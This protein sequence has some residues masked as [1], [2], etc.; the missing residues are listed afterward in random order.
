MEASKK[1]K[2]KLV[3]KLL[4]KYRLLIVNEDTYEERFSIG[5]TRL[6]VY[7]ILGLSAIILIGLTTMLIAYTPLKEYIP[8]YTSNNIKKEAIELIYKADSLERIIHR[9]NTYYTSVQR[10]LR[11][12][13]S[14]DSINTNRSV[15]SLSAEIEI[16][17]LNMK[18]SKVDSLLREKVAQEDKYNVFDVA[19]AKTNVKLFPPLKGEI[20]NAYNIAE[21]HFAVDVAAEENTPIKAV[22]DGTVIFSGWTTETG[23][24]LILEHLDGLISVYK[25]NASLA[26]EQGDFVKT[27]EVIASVGSTG[28][29]S[30]GPH[31]H[32]ELWNNGYPLN[33][34]DFIEFN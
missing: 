30:T 17:R 21:K 3:K 14:I 32:F 24:V 19:V 15:D 31:L 18:P 33:P 11:G 28:A 29:F 26:K 10:V 22:A 1:Q 2:K 16:E 5:L 12:E 20:T 23:F 13:V 25:H 27:G 7:V 34:T 6:N 8:G 9:N 4:H